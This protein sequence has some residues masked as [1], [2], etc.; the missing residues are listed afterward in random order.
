M[1]PAKSP[2]EVEPLLDA[3]LQESTSTGDATLSAP[4]LNHDALTGSAQHHNGSHATNTDWLG[5]RIVT[6]MF[7]FLVMGMIQSTTGVM[8]PHWEKHY[9]LSDTLVS[10][11]FLL[12][13]LGY[14]VAA[15]FN[16]VIHLQLG[17]RGIAVIGPICQLTFAIGLCTH[18]PYL[19]LLSLSIFGAIGTGLLDG[20][21]CAWAGAMENANTIQGF[22]HGSYSVGASFGPFI[23]GTM[24]SAAETPWWHFY[25]V[26]SVF[27]VIMLVS[28]V[29][30]FRFQDGKA[31]RAEKHDGTEQDAHARK[32]DDLAIFKHI[33]TWICAAY[34]LAYVGIESSITG[35]IVVYMIRARH[36]SGYLASICSSLFNIGMAVGRLS[37]GILTD[38]LG[39]R[40][41]I[42][43]YLST[44]AILQALFALV[45]LPAVSAAIIT[46]IGFLLG[47]MFPSGV[48]MITR[49]L[50]THL[51]VGAV[52]FVAALGEVGGALLPFA[53]GAIADRLGIGAFQYIILAQLIVTLLIW[54]CFPRL[55]P[56]TDEY[57]SL[58]RS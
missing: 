16:S 46:I 2:E 50:P 57:S 38:R 3:D 39:V 7:A 10:L 17:Q 27:C 54:M 42:M 15:Y 5:L 33:A 58:Q 32:Q 14:F 12:T 18:P 43:I 34:F 40:L 44:A 48:V 4:R 37:L 8:I 1:P 56:K 19:V 23:A 22:L 11:I 29:Y 13:P 30:A 9:G 45:E 41:A 53:L 49:L 26:L 52:S 35:W 51:H 31:Y 28:S 25:Y 24:I 6:A 20:S 36:A 55:P 21:W 47:P